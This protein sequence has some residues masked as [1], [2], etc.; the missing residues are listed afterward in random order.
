MTRKT[1]PRKIQHAQSRKRFTAAN[2]QT[3]RDLAECLGRL[4]PLE[5]YRSSFSLTVLARQ[6]G[7]LSFIPK[8]APNKKECFYA[9]VRN[10]HYQRPR[11]LKSLV[12]DILPRAI[13]RRFDHGDPVLAPEATRL[14]TVLFSLGVDMRSEIT[15]LK[16]PTERPTIVPPPP[17]AKKALESLGLHPS[18][19]PQCR[20]MFLDGHINESVRK[21]LEKFEAIVQG[22]AGLPDKIGKDLMGMAFS[23]TAPRVQLGNLVTTKEKDEQEGYKFL[24]MGMMCWWRNELSHR[25]IPQLPHHEALGRL[26]AVSNMLHRLDARA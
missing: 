11:T 8:K 10:L 9:F 24:A 17:E 6:R 26:L 12:R 2:L 7:L 14:A 15:D 5:G 19:L 21:A 25:D 16:L 4:I 18:L 22:V 3:L 1:S 13:E 23:D 20:E